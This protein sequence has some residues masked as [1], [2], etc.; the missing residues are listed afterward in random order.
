MLEQVSWVNVKVAGLPLLLLLLLLAVLSALAPAGQP[1]HLVL[2]VTLAALVTDGAVQRVVDLQPPP[3]NTHD[4]CGS[5]ITLHS[6]H[7]LVWRFN[8]MAVRHQLRQPY[9][10]HQVL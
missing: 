2:Q 3:P 8:D 1:P 6:Q 4:G 5:M 9:S 10:Y 7:R